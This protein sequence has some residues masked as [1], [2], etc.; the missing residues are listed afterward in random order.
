[1]TGPCGAGSAPVGLGSA[2][3]S[4]AARWPRGCRK[5]RL[6][7][8][9]AQEVSLSRDAVGTMRANHIQSSATEEAI[10]MEDAIFDTA[11]DLED[12][13]ARRVFFIRVYGDDDEG[14]R[15]MAEL[16]EL[17]GESAAWAKAAVGW[18][19]RPNRKSPCGGGSRSR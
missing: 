12:P 7:I 16:L 2:G 5:D 14:S 15:R 6:W 11:L 10:W 1:M 17:A 13:A 19:T 18:S 3:R 4:E 8:A 9:G